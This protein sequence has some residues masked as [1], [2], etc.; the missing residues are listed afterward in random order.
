MLK[1]WQPT[2]SK[3]ALRIRAQVLADIRSFFLVR[4][5]LEVETPLLGHGCGTD[6]QLDFFTTEY[7]CSPEED[8]LF[9][10]TSPEFAMKRLLASGSGSIY[11]ICKAF[12][13]GESGRF[14]NPEFTLLEW[15][16]LGFTLSELMDEIEELLTILF[17][18]HK[19]LCYP[20]RFS[21]EDI[22]LRHTGLNPLRFSYTDYCDYALRVGTPDAVTLCGYDHNLW[23]DFIFSH[24]I[25]S[26]LGQNAICMIYGYPAS[27]SSLAR[28][29]RRNSE[30]VDRVEVFINGIEL[31]NG[32][33]ELTNAQE[34]SARFDREIT[35]RQERKLPTVVKDKHLIAALEEGLPECSGMAIGL[36]RLLMLLT[37]NEK[38]D[39]VLNFPLSRA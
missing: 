18:G 2:C 3:E 6:P 15:Y 24:H 7:G 27:Q 34:Q 9:L 23:L 14:H 25:Q 37:S 39:D 32:Y 5:V 4:D 21:Y 35:C 22:F 38:I 33:Y 29:N 30:I 36:D 17:K 28:I 12:R 8:R 1:E 26:L 16:R 20:Q 11:Q 13:N 19:H 31:G 10:Q